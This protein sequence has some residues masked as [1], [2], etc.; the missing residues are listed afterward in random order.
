MAG[1]PVVFGTLIAADWHGRPLGL[2]V[3]GAACAVGVDLSPR[4]RPRS[5][6]EQSVQAGIGR[7]M[8]NRP[9]IKPRLTF[10][11]TWPCQ[12]IDPSSGGERG[13]RQSQRPTPRSQSGERCWRNAAPK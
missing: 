8:G 4:R 2:A 10:F 3:F 1:S 13:A 5:F 9:L 12:P 6:P 7:R 11:G